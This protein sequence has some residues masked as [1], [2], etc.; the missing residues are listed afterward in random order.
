[1][2][3]VLWCRVTGPVSGLASLGCCTGLSSPLNFISCPALKSPRGVM[4]GCACGAPAGRP[5]K[6]RPGQERHCWQRRSGAASKGPGNACRCDTATPYRCLHLRQGTGRA[7]TRLAFPKASLTSGGE[8]CRGPMLQRDV[9]GDRGRGG[10]G[11][12]ASCRCGRVP[13]AQPPRPIQGRRRRATH[14]ALAGC[15]RGQ[16]RPAPRR[17]PLGR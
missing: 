8:Q 6:P 15:Q 5:G 2:A 13:A 11:G 1:M 14:S 7:T 9:A 4:N 10:S 3:L 12:P 16:R 17:G